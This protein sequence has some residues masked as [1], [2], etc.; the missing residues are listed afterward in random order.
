MGGGG[1]LRRDTAYNAARGASN[2]AVPPCLIIHPLS[3]GDELMAMTMM[4]ELLPPKGW[5]VT[6]C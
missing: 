1:S 6:W 2:T 4:M 3:P 5:D